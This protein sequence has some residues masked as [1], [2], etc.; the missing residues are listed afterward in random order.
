[1]GDLVY[2]EEAGALVVVPLIEVSRTAVA[3]HHVVRV[4]LADGRELFISAGHPTASGTLFGDLGPGDDLGGVDVANVELV[5]YLHEYTYDILPGSS[6][7]TYVAAGA[8]I[9]STLTR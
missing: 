6:S 3:D 8:L 5:P 2:S 9:G 1:M 4:E 7:G